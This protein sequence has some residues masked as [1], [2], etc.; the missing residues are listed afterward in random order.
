MESRLILNTLFAATIS[1][2]VVSGI[3]S[4]HAIEKQE[5]EPNQLEQVEQVLSISTTDEELTPEEKFI[6]ARDGLY[7]ALD[8]SLEKVSGLTSGLE[9]KEFSASS[10]EQILKSLFIEDLNKFN[11]FYSEKR[12]V[13]GALT[14]LEEVQALAQEIKNY[15]ESVYTP[16]IETIVEFGLVFYSEDFINTANIRFEK[17]YTDIEKLT[18]LGLIEKDAFSVKMSEARTLLDEANNLLIDARFM[19]MVTPE[20]GVGISTTGTTTISTSTNVTTT[21]DGISQPTETIKIIP[22][23]QLRQP[24]GLGESELVQSEKKEPRDLLEKSL[25]NIKL[26][27]SIFLEIS[28]VINS[29]V[30]EVGE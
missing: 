25:N 22:D 30:L 6:R 15:R 19:V 29:T 2:T 21:P 28:E 27:Y 18:S 14:K 17:I 11:A 7:T 9:K 23:Q 16:T 8:L 3:S 26:A 13:L 4:A 10:T 1:I 5:S 20:S 12:V 24:P